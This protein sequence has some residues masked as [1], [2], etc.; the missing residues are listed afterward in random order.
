MAGLFP[1]SSLLLCPAQAIMF[2][3]VV[4]LTRSQD[5]QVVEAGYTYP[6]VLVTGYRSNPVKGN[7]R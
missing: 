2:C 3:Y 1:C 5:F 6:Y 4:L 7:Y